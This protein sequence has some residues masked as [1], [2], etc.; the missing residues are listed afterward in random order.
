MGGEGRGGASSLYNNT[1]INPLWR[2]AHNLIKIL[3]FF[4]FIN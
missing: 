1:I 4:F 2:M 3:K